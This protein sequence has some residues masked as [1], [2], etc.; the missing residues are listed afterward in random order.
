[1]PWN[2]SIEAQRQ[3]DE[4]WNAV[5]H[6]RKRSKPKAS[7]RKTRTVAKP[8]ISYRAYM[9]S[10]SWSRK[11][12]QAFKSLGRQCAVCFS[13]QNLS[14]HHKTYARLGRE[15]MGDLQILCGDCHR[16]HHEGHVAGVHDPLTA[17]F[18]R[19]IG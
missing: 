14:V 4:A 15:R 13:E 17:E 19:V 12:E 8:P 5:K 11:R 18:M 10:R 16:N 2:G 1:M 7:A 6:K 9:K 3:A